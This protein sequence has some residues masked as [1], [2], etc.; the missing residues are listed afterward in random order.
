MTF[1]GFLDSRKAKEAGKHKKSRGKAQSSQQSSALAPIL[2]WAAPGCQ[3]RCHWH[4][5]SLKPGRE[6]NP[7]SFRMRSTQSLVP[8]DKR[9]PQICLITS[10]FL[11]WWRPPAQFMAMSQIYERKE[12]RCKWQHGDNK[13][14]CTLFPIP[15]VHNT[16]LAFPPPENSS[17][18]PKDQHLSPLP[19]CWAVLLPAGRPQ[20]NESK[21]QRGLETLGWK[22]NHIQTQ[23]TS[24]LPFSRAQ[25]GIKLARANTWARI[26]L[27]SL[28]KS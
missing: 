24:F 20:C 8:K 27:S 22:R 13:Q 5:K 1:L 26:K 15:G 16:L 14:L 9:N 6:R 2:T 18:V 4:N 23:N 25:P 21:I 28:W 11:A 17:W 3:S 10:N 19:C 12:V 7:N